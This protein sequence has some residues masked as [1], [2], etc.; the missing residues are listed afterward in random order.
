MHYL[1]LVLVDD[2]GPIRTE[3]VSRAE[4]MLERYD[5]TREVDPYAVEIPIEEIAPFAAEQGVATDDLEALVALVPL[6]SGYY[7]GTIAE[8][9][10]SYI[11]TS[12]R[13]GYW[14]WYEHPGRFSGLIPKDLCL[15]RDLPADFDC[16]YLVTPDGEIHQPPEGG[17][18][19]GWYRTLSGILAANPDAFAV[20]MDLHR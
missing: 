4:Q 2:A 6:W 10:L 13:E 5:E 7:E 19:V 3:I 14:D 12:N 20:V 11:S 9:R 1:T 18:T 16:Y 15:V 8:G 17:L